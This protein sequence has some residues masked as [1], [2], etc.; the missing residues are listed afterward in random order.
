MIRR[1]DADVMLAG[2][3]EACI[4]P[5]AMGGFC[6]MKA[7]SEWNDEPERASRPWDAGR[8]GFVMGEGAAVMVLEDEAFARSRN[9][10]L[11]A[12]VAGYGASSDGHHITAPEPAGRG[13]ERAM[14]Q[15]LST[16]GLLPEAVDY[17]NAHGTSTRLGDLAETRA[18]RRVFGSHAEQLLVSST[19][20]V[21][22]HLLGAAGAI[23][24]AACVLA[25]TRGMVPP[26]INLEQPDSEC[27]LD[28]VANQPRRA[29]VDVAMSN[30]FGFGGHNATLVIRR[31]AA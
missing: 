24:A 13:A 14:R 6:Q 5:F 1:G 23:E 7:L 26:T 12:E 20:S 11:L 21:H 9:A 3:A 18:I 30:S 19:K 22:G 15:A 28:Y 4:T 31:S 27:D 17:I 10:R 8:D 29:A 25:I 16:T 2:G